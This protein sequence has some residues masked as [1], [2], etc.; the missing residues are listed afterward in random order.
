[1]N[2]YM[3]TYVQKNAVSICFRPI[4]ISF[5]FNEYLQNSC[6]LTK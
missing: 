3:F 1:M 2:Q 6:Q 4:F 5:Y